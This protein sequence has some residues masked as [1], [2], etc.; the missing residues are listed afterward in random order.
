MSL[1]W[2]KHLESEYLYLDLRGLSS[3]EVSKL[4]VDF[5]GMLSSIPNESL[6]LI[7]DIRG[8]SVD[9]S[10]FSMSKQ[11]AIQARPKIYRSAYVK[12]N[13]SI[14]KIFNI[15]KRVTG[16]KAVLLCSVEEAIDYV[17]SEE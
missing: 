6:R 5:G 11:V 8:Q 12:E 7:I 16:S 1:L 14:S 9:M 2:K 15:Y 17:F 3:L 13:T 10:N 4:A